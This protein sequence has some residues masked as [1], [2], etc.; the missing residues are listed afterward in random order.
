MSNNRPSDCQHCNKECTIHLT[1]ILNG[2]VKKIDMC[3]SC[4]N[5]KNFQDV[6]DFGMLE[7]LVNSEDSNRTEVKKECPTCGMTD[8]LFQKNMRFG[9]SDCFDAF[10]DEVSHVIQ[11]TQFSSVHKGKAAISSIEAQGSAQ[12]IKE[13][14]REL[15]AAIKEE[16]YEEA[17][18][19]RDQIL[20]IE[21]T[22]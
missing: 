16:K 13:L 3:E 10:E 20:Q 22:L 14:Q 17:A 8:V 2:K 6:G 7:D 12:R 9:C 11:Q 19:I 21:T 15:A 4:P 5:A 1:Q 18:T